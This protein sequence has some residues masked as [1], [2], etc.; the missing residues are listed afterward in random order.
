MISFLGAL[1]EG[2]EFHES[3]RAARGGHVGG[4]GVGGREFSGEIGEV[5][6]GELAGIGAVANCEKDER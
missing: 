6:E 2:V 4:R 3:I 5:S 1:D